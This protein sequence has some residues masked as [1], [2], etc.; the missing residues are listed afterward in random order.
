M[1]GPFA[2]DQGRETHTQTHTQTHTDVAVGL[3]K[4][5]WPK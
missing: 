4:E 2:Q 5:D 1:H 3:A